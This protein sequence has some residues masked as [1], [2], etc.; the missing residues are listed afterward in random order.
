M[1]PAAAFDTAAKAAIMLDYASGD[2]LLEKSPDEA[3]PPASLTKLMTL[4]LVFSRLKSGNLKLDDAL[5]VSA[6]AW[7]T[8][9]S[10]M[11]VRVGD[12]VKV[13][14][15]LRGVIV[16]S[17][18][19][20]CVVLAEA[21]A[22]SEDAFAQRMN[23]RAKT[24]GLE[25]STF[26]NAT[27]LP[28]DPSD[29]MSVRDLA[30]LARRI[31]H[32]YPEYYPIFAE[33]SFTFSGITQRN[34]NPLLEA[35]VPGVDGMKTGFTDA[36]GYGLVSSA[37]RDGRRIVLVLA[38]LGSV[39]QRRSE[40]ER[41]LEYGFRDFQ[42]YTLFAAGEAVATP[43]VWL[44]AASTVPLVPDGPVTAV[45]SRDG[46][47]GLTVKVRY[48]A[49]LPAPIAKG[50][51][52]G[53]IEIAAPGITTRIIPLHAA[54]DVPKAGMIGRLADAFAYLVWGGG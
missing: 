44:G 3:R 15:L 36:A 17:G 18:N 38:G 6:K 48:A 35:G 51:K 30:T 32:D 16:D 14:D 39:Q 23:E 7:R 37:E 12:R 25:H 52:L 13:S 34:R 10:K 9:G 28:A 53:E 11:F 54:D 42:Q 26:V 45:L 1:R 27:G 33:K 41:V 46:R 43:R 22:G 29:M 5:P 40:G 31:I 2:V 47:K 21:L 49:P 20:A 19:D 24:I 4:D 50:Q 8:G